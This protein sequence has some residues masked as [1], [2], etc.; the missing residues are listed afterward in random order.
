MR[1]DLSHARPSERLL[2]PTRAVSH[3]IISLAGERKTGDRRGVIAVNACGGN[4][5]QCIAILCTR[6]YCMSEVLFNKAKS[7]SSKDAGRFCRH[8]FISTRVKQEFQKTNPAIFR[9]G[10]HHFTT[11]VIVNIILYR[12]VT[13]RQEYLNIK[14]CHYLVTLMLFQSHCSM[15]GNYD[16]P[17]N[18]KTQ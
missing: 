13:V 2:W 4:E 11:N 9:K 16:A 18:T 1:Q 15:R 7:W 10:L 12:G 14:L 8:I 5:T 6:R 17:K 3:A